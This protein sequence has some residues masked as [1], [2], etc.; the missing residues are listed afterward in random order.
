M[1][2]LDFNSKGVEFNDLYCNAYRNILIKGDILEYDFSSFDYIYS[3]NPLSNGELMVKALDNIL[4]T[5]KKG[6]ILYFVKAG[7]YSFDFKKY[8][9]VSNVFD[10]VGREMWD[11][12]KIV[13]K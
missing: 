13:K 7:G 12:H 5:M 3:Y 10:S 2:I 8:G 11:V 9:T 1:N 4:S 6:A